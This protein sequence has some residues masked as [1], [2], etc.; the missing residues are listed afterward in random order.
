MILCTWSLWRYCG[1]RNS[2][3]WWRISQR[4][5]C[6]S[7]CFETRKSRHIK[8]TCR[9]Q[10]TSSS[11]TAIHSTKSTLGLPS[12]PKSIQYHHF[13]QWAGSKVSLSLTNPSSHKQLTPH[14]WLRPSSG[15]WPSCQSST[16]SQLVSRIDRRRGC[17][18]SSKGFWRSCF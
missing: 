1:I 12:S 11:L 4:C 5:F 2:S 18:R 7:W 14:R 8:D 16:W 13:S 15:L 10:N 9:H 17:F 3:S 6:V